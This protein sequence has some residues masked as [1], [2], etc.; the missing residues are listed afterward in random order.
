[1]ISR[2]MGVQSREGFRPAQGGSRGSG[3]RPRD[4]VSG[5]PAYG[6]GRVRNHAAYM[7]ECYS[8]E[9]DAVDNVPCLAC[10]DQAA[11]VVPCRPF[12]K[13]PPRRQP[14]RLL[15]VIALP[16]SS[17]DTSIHEAALGPSDVDKKSQSR[18][19]LAQV[20]QAMSTDYRCATMAS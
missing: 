13:H 3:F 19:R 10:H 7:W 6:R 8:G 9:R 16:V 11:H 18:S 2:V 1:M 5:Q 14:P 4:A 17:G 12:I 20:L 15:C